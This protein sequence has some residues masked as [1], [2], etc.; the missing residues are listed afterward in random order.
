MTTEPSTIKVN[1]IQ[2]AIAQLR[3]AIRLWF[4]GDDPISAHALAFAAYEVIHTVSK[5]RNKYR[6]DL[7]F[8]TDWIKDE[9]RSDWNITLKKEAYFF[10]HAD[11]EPE[12]E[13]EF[14]PEKTWGFILYAIAGRELSGEPQSEE[15]SIFLWWLQIHEPHFLTESGRKFMAD[16]VPIEALE[17]VRTLPK[18]QFFKA[19]SEARRQARNGGPRIGTP[20][21]HIV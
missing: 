20:R 7:L 19:W 3:T 17:Q 6:R 21:L 4:A 1:K 5:K 15:E 8:D 14:N 12:G 11:R 10:K 9:Y 13:I 16:H 2:A 18:H